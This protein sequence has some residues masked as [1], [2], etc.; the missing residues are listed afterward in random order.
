MNRVLSRVKGC[1]GLFHYLSINTNKPPCNCVKHT[2]LVRNN[3]FCI[4]QFGLEYV[5]LYRFIIYRV[6]HMQSW[7]DADN[8]RVT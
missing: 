8:V 7:H 1:P 4:G 6:C 5:L 3:G 2:Y